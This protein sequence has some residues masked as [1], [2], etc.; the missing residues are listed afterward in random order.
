MLNKLQYPK[1]YTTLPI[2]GKKINFR[3]YT[4]GEM[5]QLLLQVEAEEENGLIKDTVDTCTVDP[6]PANLS[7]ADIEWLFLQ[8]RSKSSGEELELIHTC[9]HCKEKNPFTINFEKD[10]QVRNKENTNAIEIQGTTIILDDPAVKY[11]EAVKA[12][13][14]Q[15]NVDALLADCITSVTQGE[16]TYP[17]KDIPEEERI[18]FIQ[19][20]IQKDYSRLE[21][22]YL[23]RPKLYYHYEYKC[24][25]CE[26]ENEIHIEGASSFFW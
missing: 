17:K 13:P 9:K 4:T 1:F 8:I 14:K 26:G 19:G 2:S 16:V 6:L 22:W 11:I 23:N 21:N 12:D 20:M 3:P 15:E 24:R 18:E 25:K 5:K 10:I 7:P